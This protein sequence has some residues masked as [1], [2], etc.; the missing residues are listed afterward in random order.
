MDGWEWTKV[1]T[2]VTAAVA[3]MLS[4]YWFAGELINVDYPEARGYGIEGDVPVDLAALQRAWPAGM[5]QTGD[6]AELSGYMNHNETAVP[7]GSAAGP[8]HGEQ[9]LP[10]ALGTPPAAHAQAVGGGVG[11]GKIGRA[12]C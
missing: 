12:S 5:H 10:V 3:V 4:G 2:A 6:P 9:V 8:G 7:P 11:R 1:G